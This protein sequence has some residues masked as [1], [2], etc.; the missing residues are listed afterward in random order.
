[1]INVWVNNGHDGHQA[2]ESGTKVPLPETDTYFGGYTNGY[3]QV[4]KWYT[5]LQEVA[6]EGFFADYKGCNVN[7][8]DLFSYKLSINVERSSPA[9]RD[10]FFLIR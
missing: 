2:S 8:N 9:G 4:Y 5:E 3:R 7:I 6:A 1:M 10:S